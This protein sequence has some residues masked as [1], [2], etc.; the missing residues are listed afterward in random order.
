MGD[1]D[2]NPR[3]FRFEAISAQNPRSVEVLDKAW[4]YEGAGS[5]AYILC[6]HLQAT[7]PTLRCWN[8]T[9]F[10]NIHHK[11]RRL[12]DELDNV[13]QQISSEGGAWATNHEK[14]ISAQLLEAQQDVETLQRQKSSITWLKTSNLNTKFFYLSTITRCWWNCIDVG[15]QTNTGEWIHGRIDIGSHIQKYFEGIFSGQQAAFP[16]YLEDLIPPVITV[17][18]NELLC[19]IPDA[20]EI[21][22]AIKS[23][24]GTE[25]PGLDGFIDLFCHRYWSLVGHEVTHMVQNFLLMDTCYGS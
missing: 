22:T 8:R 20:L 15:L 19:R 25:A 7:K 23:I 13:Q 12:Q 21:T 16:S 14:E 3:P 11:V 6:Q 24:G 4:Q 17:E 18:D 10:G 1:T 9:V 5:P 2:N